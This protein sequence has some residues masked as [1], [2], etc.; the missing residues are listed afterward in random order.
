VGALQKIE[1]RL[2][3]SCNTLRSA[4][5]NHSGPPRSMLHVV[6]DRLDSGA[7]GSNSAW[8]YVYFLVVC[9]ALCW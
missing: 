6:L 9:V 5:A 4:T 3:V 7:S 1:F 2:V 8:I